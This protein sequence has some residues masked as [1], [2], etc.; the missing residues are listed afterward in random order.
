MIQYLIY[1]QRRRSRMGSFNTT[2]IVSQQ[3]IA[4]S[5][6]VV[7][8]PIVQQSSYAPVELINKDG[9]R[10]EA[11]GHSSSSCYPT[12]FWMYAGP[13]LIGEY[14]DYGKF[15]LENTGNNIENIKQFF[16]IINRSAFKTVGGKNQY[17][18]VPFDMSKIYTEAK[19]YTFKE[20]DE[21]WKQIEDVVAECR[22]FVRGITHGDKPK[23]LQF[24]VMHKT[25]ADYL[26]KDVES[27]MGYNNESYEKRDFFN[28]YLEQYELLRSLV[29]RIPS[30]DGYGMGDQE[31]AYISRLYSSKVAF[32]LV[33]AESNKAEGMN[34]KALG[35]KLFELL[36]S[37]IDHRYIHVGLDRLNIKLTPMAYSGQDYANEAGKNYAGM[38]RSVRTALLK[39][40]KEEV[41]A[42][43]SSR[44]KM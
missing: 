24:A 8:F 23:S 7:I 34:I 10:M 42:N 17:H 19:D 9:S 12:A 27:S 22:L 15:E 25:A 28:K 26:T 11:Y 32:D 2:C 31:G 30:L 37:N 20:L 3:V 39:L 21:I 18:E 41:I 38:V 6:K 35:D 5:D 36:K 14:D 29:M 4:T 13:M 1:I 33:N 16:N 44:H 43:K 40:K